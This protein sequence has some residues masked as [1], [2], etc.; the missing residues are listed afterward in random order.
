MK[1][2]TFMLT[3]GLC[4]TIVC[5]GCVPAVFMAGVAS[6]TVGGVIVHD[7]RSYSTMTEDH[8]ARVVAQKRLDHN[9]ALCGHAHITVSVFNRSALLLGQAQSSE[10]RKKAYRLI[11]GIPGIER[12]YNEIVVGPPSTPM[13]RTK[14]SWITTKVRTAMLGT[15]G[16]ESSN[17]KVVTENAVVYLMGR[18]SAP[19]AQL[20]SS[21]TRKISGVKK[22]V[23]VFSYQ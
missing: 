18:V 6:A 22:V 5:S 19:Q 7:K 15:A 16:L 3:V 13:Q 2:K 10:L 1:P 20:A 12:V 4:S 9:P 11:A 17:L 23:T 21:V 8:H 14:D